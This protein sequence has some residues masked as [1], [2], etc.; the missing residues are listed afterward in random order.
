M[1]RFTSLESIEFINVAQFHK[2]AKFFINTENEIQFAK[3]IKHLSMNACFIPDEEHAEAFINIREFTL[4]FPSVTRL[5]FKG[6]RIGEHLGDMIA[7][8]KRPQIEELSF[9]LNGIEPEFT[10][11]FQMCLN[12]ETI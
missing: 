8:C 11:Y 10:L 4:L 5:H 3:T 1:I 9:E 2:I 12:F 6:L 7:A